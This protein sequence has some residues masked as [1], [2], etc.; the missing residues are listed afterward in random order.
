MN[1]LSHLE[2]MKRPKSSSAVARIVSALRTSILS[3]ADGE[4]LGSEEQLTARYGVSRPTLRQAVRLLEHERLLV[5]KR[6]SGGGFYARRPQI[7]A[8]AHAAAIYLDIEQATFR[9]LI[10]ASLPLLTEAVQLAAAC[11]D[12][13]LHARL[14]QL[15]VNDDPEAG[16]ME[17]RPDEVFAWDIEFARIIG[18]MC[19]NPVIKLFVS[20]IYEFGQSQWRDEL[21]LRYGRHL[22]EL[23]NVRNQLIRAILSGDAELARLYGQ[24]RSMLVCKLIQNLPGLEPISI[25]TYDAARSS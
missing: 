17:G 22:P 11:R 3:A 21:G 12:E 4:Y 14:R 19:G 20:I 8:V 13:R 5:I 10:T 7:D 18:D 1:D 15:L 6:G 16:K 23:Y 24:R 9:D 2:P 25:G